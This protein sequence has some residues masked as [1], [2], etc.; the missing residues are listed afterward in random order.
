MQHVSTAEFF[1]NGYVLALIVMASMILYGSF[2]QNSYYLSVR[3]GI[4]IKAA[5]QVRRFKN[6]FIS[7]Q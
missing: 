5:L 7:V 2:Q 3:Q 4:R 6:V 1:Q